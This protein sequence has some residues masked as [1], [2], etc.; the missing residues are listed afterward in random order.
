MEKKERPDTSDHLRLAVS[1]YPLTRTSVREP[2]VSIFNITIYTSDLFEK[3]GVPLRTSTPKGGSTY[4]DT[5][6]TLNTV[7]TQNG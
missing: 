2:I 6:I 1:L 3:R 5:T 4:H 7:F